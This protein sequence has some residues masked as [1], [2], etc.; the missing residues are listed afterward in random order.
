MSRRPGRR[1]SVRPSAAIAASSRSVID[2]R[3]RLARL[4]H[5]Q[6]H[7]SILRDSKG[8]AISV[9]GIDWDVTKEE[10][11]K[12]EISRQATEIKEA[13]ERFQRAVSGTQD[14]LFEFNL[15]TGEIWHSPQF[16]KMLGYDGAERSD[17]GRP[18]AFVHP[19]DGAIVGKAMSDHLQQ[20]HSVRH[21]VSPAQERRRLVMGAL[22]R[23]RRARCRQSADVARRLD[24]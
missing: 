8:Y 5:V 19:D 6:T 16:R 15:Q 23:L 2:D 1:C 18:E 10:Q 14:A 24:S 3:R 7:A 12:D 4:R 17:E 21:R 9:L 13:Q 20:R 22:A 11:A